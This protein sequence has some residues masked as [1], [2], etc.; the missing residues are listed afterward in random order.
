MWGR[1]FFRTHYY[2]LA[3]IIQDDAFYYLLPAWNC[4]RLGWFTFDGVTQ[5]YGFQPLWELA[6]VVL[7]RLMPTREL[8]L[9]AALVAGAVL[10]AGT[11]VVLAGAAR[12]AWRSVRGDGGDVA[13][14]VA[15][16][17]LLLNLP[18]AMANSAAKEMPSMAS[19]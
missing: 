15:A 14:A 3:T 1:Y 7:A 5:T 8:F 18:V 17:M 12:A 19:C 4:S 6:L 2:T 16:A 11:S 13:G 9:R 10:Y